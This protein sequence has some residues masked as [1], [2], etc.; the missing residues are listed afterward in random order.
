MNAIGQSVNRQDGRLKVTGGATY[1]AEWSLPQMTHAV[2]VQSAIAKGTVDFDLAAA[3][4]APGVLFVMTHLNRPPLAPPKS[5]ESVGM[6]VGESTLP[7]KDNVIRFNGQ[8]I[9]LVVAET[10]EQARYAATLV[11][12]TYKTDAPLIEMEKGRATAKKPA[13]SPGREAQVVRGTPDSAYESSAQK[14]EAVY[15][16]PHEHHHP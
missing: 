3:Q 10:Y 11:K 14:F 13:G 7:L 1:S 15:K 8:M 12:A 4:T 16:T 5:L 2:A 6:Q 9:A